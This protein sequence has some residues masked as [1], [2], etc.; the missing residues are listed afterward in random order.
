MDALFISVPLDMELLNLVPVASNILE[1]SRLGES[2]LC[3]DNFH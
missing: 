3:N 2:I 1:I